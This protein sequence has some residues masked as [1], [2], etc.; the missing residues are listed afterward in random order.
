MFVGGGDLCGFANMV[1]TVRYVSGRVMGH[2]EAEDVL[3]AVLV[4]HAELNCTPTVLHN[5]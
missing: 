2:G 1:R 5:K 4:H 3:H